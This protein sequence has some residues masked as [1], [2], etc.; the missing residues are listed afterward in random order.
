[1]SASELESA[2]PLLII[3]VIEAFTINYFLQR[4]FLILVSIHV[5]LCHIFAYLACFSSI[6]LTLFM[7][8]CYY[9]Q[10]V[11]TMPSDTTPDNTKSFANV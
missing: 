2:V 1:M 8:F 6:L 3:I 11:P 4:Y 9:L 10:R 5:V 7:L